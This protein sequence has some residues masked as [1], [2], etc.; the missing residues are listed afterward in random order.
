MKIILFVFSLAISISAIAQ[1]DMRF[2]ADPDQASS[3]FTSQT[4]LIR[5]GQITKNQTSRLYLPTGEYQVHWRRSQIQQYDSIYTGRGWK[6]SQVDLW[7]GY[8]LGE[9][10]Q[11]TA[12]T[13]D[14]RINSVNWIDDGKAYQLTRQ[15]TGKYSFSMLQ[16]IELADGGI[17]GFEAMVNRG[18]PLQPARLAYTSCQLIEFQLVTDLALNASPEQFAIAEAKMIEWFAIVQTYFISFD[19]DFKL[20]IKQLVIPIDESPFPARDDP[21]VKSFGDINFHL[22]NWLEEKGI[23][24]SLFDFTMG[25]TQFNYPTGNFIG[26]LFAG[27]ENSLGIVL[28]E[29]Q[30]SLSYTVATIVHEVGHGFGAGHDPTTGYIMSADLSGGS[31][32]SKSKYEINEYMSSEEVLAHLNE[33][34]R[35]VFSAEIDEKKVNL[36]WETDYEYNVSYYVL[37]LADNGILDTI[38]AIGKEN[39]PVSYQFVHENP[40]NIRNIYRIYQFSVFDEQLTSANIA[41]DLSGAKGQDGTTYGPNP[42]N[43]HLYVDLADPTDEL[44][45]YDISGRIYFQGHLSETSFDLATGVWKKGLYFVRVNNEVFKVIKE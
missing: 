20:R 23:S 32:S 19:I 2:V 24:A 43:E 28:I 10:S 15:A 30:S 40:G 7:E 4:G 29:E 3:R 38:P 42:F 11:F 21:S 12:T 36:T 26:H 37:V 31:W 13:V 5:G 39:E 35:L 18:A 1:N 45:I 44:I 17:C 41:V 34:P 8:S 25:I 22:R 9:R 14:K 16:P 6:A 27:P 33:C